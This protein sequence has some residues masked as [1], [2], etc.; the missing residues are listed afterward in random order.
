MAHPPD[1]LNCASRVVRVQLYARGALVVRD[2]SLPETPTAA[3]TL[4]IAGV[5]PLALPGSFRVHVQGE[6]AVI[7]VRSALAL[8]AHSPPASGRAAALREL[9]ARERTLAARLDVIAR[10]H[11]LLLGHPPQLGLRGRRRDPAVAQRMRDGIATAKLLR[12][13]RH[14]VDDELREATEAMA[15]I[16]RELTAARLDL[17]QSSAPENTSEDHPTRTVF[18]KLAQGDATLTSLELSYEVEAARWWPT[19]TVRLSDSA[20]HAHLSVEAFIAQDTFEDWRDV[21]LSLVTADRSRDVRLPELPSLRLGPPRVPRP[22][23]FRAPPEG[24]DRLFDAYDELTQRTQPPPPP[25]PHTFFEEE[26]AE[27]G[28]YSSNTRTQAGSVSPEAAKAFDALIAGD[29]PTRMLGLSEA[30]RPQ[31][32]KKRASGRRRTSREQVSAAKMRAFDEEDDCDDLDGFGGPGEATA[33]FDL[34]D[35]WLDFDRLHL[36]GAQHPSRGRLVPQA[37]RDV[38][39]LQRAARDRIEGLTPPAQ[40]SDPLTARGHFDH[41]YVARGEAEIPSDGRAHRVPLCEAEAAS[42]TR[43]RAL[44]LTIDQVFREISLINPF[45]APL[46]SGPADVFVDGALVL[47]SSVSNTDRGGTLTLGLGVEERLQIAR[48]VRTR[49]DRSG[50]LKGTT[51]IHHEVSIELASALAFPVTIDVIDRLPISD[52]KDITVHDFSATPASTPYRQEERGAPVDSGLR[53]TFELPPNGREEILFQFMIK[54]P[55]KYE[56]IGGNRRE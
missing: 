52:D 26:P 17:A 6:R 27:P 38:R 39:P 25:S 19:Y 33:A 50:L 34:D 24:L 49:E 28:A 51:E 37:E 45:N 1:H 53:W 48:N 47:T 29:E 32:A 30:P 3:T 41:R 31:K 56:I 15:S 14:A 12:R 2:L 5:T 21:E 43:F 42:T 36:T 40:T 54:I 13:L 11:T 10:R 8:P 23:G 7:G 9:E 18:I 16:Q 22:T 20:R 46:L 55:S 35:A 4:V 44:P